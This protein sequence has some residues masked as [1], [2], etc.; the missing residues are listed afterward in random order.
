[1]YRVDQP[2]SLAG[3]DCTAR[4]SWREV[5][6]GIAAYVQCSSMHCHRRGPRAWRDGTG[7]SDKLTVSA[8]EGT[9]RKQAGRQ[10]RRHN[11]Q[12]C[13]FYLNSLPTVTRADTRLLVSPK[14]SY[15]H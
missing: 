1:M 8:G 6:T 2:V 11:G 15:K 10:R 13:H 14:C 12:Q 9:G 7:W 5:K 4:Q 3:L